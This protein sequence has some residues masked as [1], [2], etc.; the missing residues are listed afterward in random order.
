MENVTEKNN[1]GKP[2]V[3]V[4]RLLPIRLRHVMDIFEAK[5]LTWEKR[6]CTQGVCYQNRT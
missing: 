4:A 5:V 6:G 2:S 3:D 1:K